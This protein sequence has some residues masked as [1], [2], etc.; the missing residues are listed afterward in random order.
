MSRQ[1]NA[2]VRISQATLE[3]GGYYTE[4]DTITEQLQGLLDREKIRECLV[5]LAR[6]EDRR[7]ADII[8]ASCWPDST[9]DYG[10]FQGTFQQYLA[11]VVP[12][13][14]AIKNTQHVLG[15]S[16]I[17]VQGNAARAET[18]VISY[19]RIAAGTRAVLCG[20]PV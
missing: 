7:A 3:P 1:S 9:T 2:V 5:R 12:G 14:D 16:V 4:M 17:E 19:H 11:W 18:H 20:Q 10:V 15:Q 13:S 6:G 8:S